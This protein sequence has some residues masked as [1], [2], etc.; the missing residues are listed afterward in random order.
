MEPYNLNERIKVIEFYF[1]NNRSI[2]HTQRAYRRH[3]NLRNAPSE[4]MIRR[5]VARFQQHG[6]VMDLPRGGRPRSARNEENIQRVQESV[7]EN[8][9]TLTRR[10]SAELQMLSFGRLYAEFLKIYIFFHIKCS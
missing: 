8:S 7:E 1:E 10:R 6:T 4:A 9:E 5:L 3:F 2:I